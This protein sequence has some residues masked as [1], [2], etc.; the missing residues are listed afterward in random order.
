[1]PLDL[2]DG[3]AVLRRFE[4]L[5][6]NRSNFETLWEEVATHVV[7]A[8]SFTNTRSPG[9]KRTQHIFDTTALHAGNQL[10]GIF[11]GVLTNPAS[12]WYFLDAEPE[13]AIH[14]RDAK[15]WLDRADAVLQILFRR[16]EFGFLTA[17][18]E[19]YR[20]D[21]HFGTSCIFV[22]DR[23]GRGVQYQSIPLS[24]LYFDEDDY[25]QPDLLFRHH[26][27]TLRQFV[28]RYGEKNL[29]EKMK[30]RYEKS[31]E[32][33]TEV[34]QCVHRRS[35]ASGGPR[36]IRPWRSV[37]VMKEEK[38]VVQ[39]S[40]YWSRPFHI[41]RLTKD[42][43]ELYGRGPTIFSLS[44]AKMLNEMCKTRLVIAQKQSDPP[45][46]VSHE[47]ILSQLNTGPGGVTVSEGFAL[48]QGRRPLVP[49]YDGNGS[50]WIIT[51][52]AIEAT[53]RSVR[54]HYIGDALAAQLQQYM[55]ATQTIEISQIVTQRL[56]S[57]VSRI[58]VEKI[59]PMLA[60]TLDVA[61]RGGL[62]P[63]R[64]LSLRGARIRARFLSPVERAQ[65]QEEFRAV[66]GTWTAAAQI[67]PVHPDV[68]DN[69]DPDTAARLLPEMQ[70]APPQIMRSIEERDELRE[71]RAQR[72]AAQAQ[73]EQFAQGAEVASKLLPA[74]AKASQ[75]Q[76]A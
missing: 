45:L 30:N 27:M 16:G 8:R 51:E 22:E 66:I 50:G 46:L 63:P 73:A 58:Q 57:Q 12:R 55:T 18:A 10:A 48:E 6:G 38:K 68:F 65:R 56:L 24:E 23:P 7:G 29:G 2:S 1:V 37:H 49:L 59:E 9:E 72:E 21:V 39:E 20:D 40:G 44:D 4:A 47:G 61:E 62:L 25:G 28:S 43:G 13:S 15:A 60:R 52:K 5:K 41:S 14:D 42:T 32:D 70:G 34:V 69:F 74:L 71:I 31:P 19:N 17:I 36:D 75:A 76:A 67:A 54:E 26:K 64:P 35:D 53:Q 3:K 11:H 33:T